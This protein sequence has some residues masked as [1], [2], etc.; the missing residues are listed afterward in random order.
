VVRLPSLLRKLPCRANIAD[1]RKTLIVVGVLSALGLR[2]T[3]GHAAHREAKDREANERAAKRAC[4]NGDATKGVQILTDLYIESNDPTYL[5]NQ[6]RCY[7]QNNRYEDAIG[8][9]REYLRK[10]NGSSSSDNADAASAEKHIA[11]CESLLGKKVAEPT[12][13]AAAPV[14]ASSAEPQ[15]APVLQSPP[16]LTAQPQP[17]SAE[18]SCALCKV[19]V[20]TAAVGGAALIAGLVLNLKANSM[21]GDTESRYSASAYSSAK[22]YKTMSEISYGAGAALVVGGAVLYFLGAN[23]TP[24]VATAGNHYAGVAFQGA[25]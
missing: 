5:Y 20:T 3:L 24:V 23:S 12:T 15:P 18:P 1:M 22:D 9:F 10:V 14:A 25:F 2:P 17:P 8:R 4:L 16:T 21:I 11:D 7:E 6:G 19:G 13:P